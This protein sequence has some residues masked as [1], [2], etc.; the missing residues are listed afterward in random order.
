[1]LEERPDGIINISFDGRWL[2]IFKERAKGETV[3]I[4]G[5]TLL[6]ERKGV[7]KFSLPPPPMTPKEYLD[8]IDISREMKILESWKKKGSD[9][10][11][12][13]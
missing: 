11:E 10:N 9:T 2:L 12:L 4:D 6:Q 8:S 7:T 3:E 1:M 13:I 5:E